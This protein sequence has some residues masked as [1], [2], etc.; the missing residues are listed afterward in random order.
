MQKGRPAGGGRGA[1]EW[2]GAGGSE[3]AAGRGRNQSGAESVGSAAR[4]ARVAA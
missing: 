3:D 2:L 1:V 4:R